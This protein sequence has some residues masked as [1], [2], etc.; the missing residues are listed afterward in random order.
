MLPVT[1]IC[2]NRAPLIKWCSEAVQMKLYALL[3]QQGTSQPKTSTF[4]LAFE[5]CLHVPCLWKHYSIS[6]FPQTSH[7]KLR[8]DEEQSKSC[9]C[10]L[11]YFTRMLL[12]A[13]DPSFLP[14]HCWINHT[15]LIEAI[16]IWAVPARV[17]RDDLAS[18][19]LRLQQLAVSWRR[20]LYFTT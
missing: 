6:S 13:E 10:P 7:E 9:V 8:L 5:S 11:F 19:R 20:N 16:T 17:T 14:S 15:V 3:S 18:E 2:N 1:S 12:G 4:F